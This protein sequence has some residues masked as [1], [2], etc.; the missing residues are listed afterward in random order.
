MRTIRLAV[1]ASIF[2]AGN[3]PAFADLVG[4]TVAAVSYL[5]TSNPPAGPTSVPALSPTPDCT[6]IQYCNILNYPVGQSSQN[7]PFPVIPSAGLNYLEDALTLTTV[8]I[9]KNQIMIANNAP[10]GTPFCF[11]SSLPVCPTD[12]NQQFSGFGF[13][14]SSGV[15]ITIVTASGVPDFQPIGLSWTADSII[16]NLNGT[17]P[18][19][20]STLTL[21]VTFAGTP[22]VPE[23]S[24]WTMMLAGF[25]GLG[26]AGYRAS[27][28][29]AST[30]A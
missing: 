2:I 14:F 27:R 23:P 7:F 17:L 3:G 30:P 15:D 8:S 26:F 21:N 10:S 13:Y 19:E 16:V 18:N 5:S 9:T 11:F 1:L 20:G 6:T 25:A 29:I 28:K 24:T 22:T 12:P 4:A